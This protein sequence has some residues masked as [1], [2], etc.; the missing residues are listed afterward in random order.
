MQCWL[1]S[2]IAQHSPFS[3]KSEITFPKILH[4][5]SLLT[6]LPLLPVRLKLGVTYIEKLFHTDVQNCRPYLFFACRV[7]SIS[8]RVLTSKVTTSCD[9]HDSRLCLIRLEIFYQ[10]LL[11]HSLRP[12]SD[13][14]KSLSAYLS[15]NIH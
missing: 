12:L 10:S 1:R 14:V 7:L 13:K 2:N 9:V 5:V 3:R 6:A 11:E 8:L 15:D 4:I